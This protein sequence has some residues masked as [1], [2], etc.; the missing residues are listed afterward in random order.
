MVGATLLL[1][2]NA[3]H[4]DS[5]EIK[6]ILGLIPVLAGAEFVRGGTKK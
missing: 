6:V 3:S 4:F 2:M 1:W 5:T